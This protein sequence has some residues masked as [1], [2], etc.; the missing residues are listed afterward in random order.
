[1]RGRTIFIKILDKRL[2]LI[3][4]G[5]ITK[6]KAVKMTIKVKQLT[7]EQA[8]PVKYKTSNTKYRL[9]ITVGQQEYKLRKKLFQ[10]G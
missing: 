1:M 8:I 5:S 10:Q 9:T 7:T 4:N 2:C 3:Y 6:R